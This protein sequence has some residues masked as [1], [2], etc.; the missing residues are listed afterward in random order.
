MEGS[1]SGGIVLIVVGRI[2]FQNNLVVWAGK[3]RLQLYS[4]G[5]G[6][7]LNT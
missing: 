4:L 7:K 6:P 1:D 2:F 3:L 5:E